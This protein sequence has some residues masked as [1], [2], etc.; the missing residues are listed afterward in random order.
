MNHHTI[1]KDEIVEFEDELGDYQFEDDIT[2]DEL[3]EEE[4]KVLEEEKLINEIDDDIV[5]DPLT[6]SKRK[7]LDEHGCQK[8]FE[9]NSILGR[10]TP[11]KKTKEIV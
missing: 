4:E 1:D 7:R 10:C 3:P 9:W 2:D 5:I 11:I 8:G 6:G